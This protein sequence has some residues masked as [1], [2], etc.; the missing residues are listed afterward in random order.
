MEE[1]RPQTPMIHEGKEHLLCRNYQH[2]GVKQ[3]G[4]DSR[5]LQATFYAGLGEFSRRIR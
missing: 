3:N 1:G 4:N 5:G 2:A